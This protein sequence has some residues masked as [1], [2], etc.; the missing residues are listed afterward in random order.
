MDAKFSAFVKTHRFGKRATHPL[1]RS[2]E[3]LTLSLVLAGMSL[4][5]PRFAPAT[6]LPAPS[7]ASNC[8]F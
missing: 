4:R 1:A 2:A 7:G 3:R 6:R 5:R 8:G